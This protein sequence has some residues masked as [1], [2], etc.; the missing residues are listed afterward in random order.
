[1][2]I[3]I[4]NTGCKQAINTIAKKLDS[5][6]KCNQHHDYTLNLYSKN[7][8]KA[9]LVTDKNADGFRNVSLLRINP[10][11]ILGLKRIFVAIG[12]K[13]GNIIINDKPFLMRAKTVLKKAK[14]TLEAMHKEIN[15]TTQIEHSNAISTKETLDS[16]KKL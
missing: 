11:S 15:T 4:T 13:T 9:Q 10:N 16:Y 2:N 7:K 6:C 5:S 1:M 8:L 12:N 14:S 3:R